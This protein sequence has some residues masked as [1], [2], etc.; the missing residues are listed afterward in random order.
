MVMYSIVV[1]FEYVN[2]LFKPLEIMS[3]S[4]KCLLVSCSFFIV[5]QALHSLN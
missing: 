2:T 3:S 1:N 5:G 4:L